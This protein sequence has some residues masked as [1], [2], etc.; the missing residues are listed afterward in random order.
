MSDDAREASAPS[1]AG[2]TETWPTR[3]VRVTFFED[4]AEVIREARADL[5][6]G[7]GMVTLGGLSPFVDDRSLEAEIA[8]EGGGARV[9]S[10]RVRRRAHLERALGREE[11]EALEAKERAA[12]RAVKEQDLALDRAAQ[13]DKQARSLLDRWIAAAGSVPRGA[14]DPDALGSFREALAAVEESAAK[15]LAQMAAAR[16]ARQR[17][18]DELAAAKARLAAGRVE[19]P[20][21]EALVEIELSSPD[22]RPVDLRVRYRVPSALWRP[23]HTVKLAAV[24]RS[25]ETSKIALTTL[26]TCW[27]RT[28][29]RWDDIEAR[30]ST[31][32]PARVASPPL[33]GDDVLHARRKTEQEMKRVE[34]GLREQAVEAAGLDRGTRAV[35]EM[36]GVDD[37]G[38]PLLFA[39]REKVTIPSDG[40]PFR[41]EVGAVEVDAVIERVI[42]PELGNAAHLRATATLPGGRPLLAGPLRIFRGQSLVGRGKLDFVGA[43]EPFEV[44]LGADDGVRARR[45]VTEQRDTVAVIG[46]Q[47][48]KRQVTIFLSNLS[49]EPKRALVCERV[50]VSE[51]EDVQISLG[52]AAGFAHDEKD[53]FLRREIALAP[54]AVETVDLSYEIRAG[55]KVILPF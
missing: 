20:R 39:A 9:L 52:E 43:G 22:A 41:V 15:A 28:G 31:A 50:P 12:A 46:T 36:P 51:I 16:E 30:F 4:R 8:G 34:V 3:A 44:G 23:E 14:R 38:E 55:A 27:Q 17:A 24:P 1:N 33:L 2:P 6:A 18:S 11:I 5:G 26:A 40:R 29:E 35:E 54:G 45:A 25:G 13:A 48:I 42:F 21:Y 37:G 7:P 10:A 19:R 49:G 47:K 32:R 53:G